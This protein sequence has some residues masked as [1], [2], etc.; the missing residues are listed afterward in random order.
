MDVLS[1]GLWC[2]ATFGRKSKKYFWAS[3]AIGVLPDLLP[4][5]LEFFRYLFFG[6]DFDHPTPKIFP[7]YVFY[8]Y[9]FTHSLII[10]SLVFLSLWLFKRK[11]Y[12]PLGAWGLHILM[13]IPTHS[14]KFFPTPFLWP[15]SDFTIN[16]TSWGTPLI[17]F[18]NWGALALIYL[19]IQLSKKKRAVLQ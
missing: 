19:A 15:V 3:F 11:P 8:F 13:D 9:S 7:D 16:G 18:G 5:T 4:F 12:L 17:F 14:D 2:G 10:F 6:F 1:H